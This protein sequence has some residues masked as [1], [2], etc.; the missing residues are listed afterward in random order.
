MRMIAIATVLATTLF[1]VMAADNDDATAGVD[2]TAA[3]RSADQWLALVDAADYGESWELA[4]Q[5]VREAM[6]KV[7]WE[8]TLQELRKKLGG[9]VRRKLRAATY[10]KDPPN[11]PPGEY[12]VIRYDTTF[13]NRPL[14]V[15][16]ITPV[17]Q[18]DGHW[19]VS[20]YFIR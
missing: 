11:A 14:A 2:V 7:Q 1:T 16:T 13:E 19:R 9:V 17:R 8:V 3:M 6:P 5:P 10:A 4:A 12:V 18:P 20:G 15:E